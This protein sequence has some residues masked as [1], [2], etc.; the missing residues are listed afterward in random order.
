M[1]ISIGCGREF[2]R[3]PMAACSF[4]IH[5]IKKFG[6]NVTRIQWISDVCNYNS[7]VI[8][9]DNDKLDIITSA[10][11]IIWLNDKSHSFEFDSIWTQQC[12]TKPFCLKK[13]GCSSTYRTDLAILAYRNTRNVNQ[14]N[15]KYLIENLN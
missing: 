2:W 15:W 4:V 10:K 5:T 7:C 12:H 11:T 14:T 1:K 8:Y 13:Y 9:D 6:S 3:I